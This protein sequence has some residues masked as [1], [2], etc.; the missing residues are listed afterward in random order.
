[1]ARAALRLAAIVGLVAACT[2]SVT[3]VSPTPTVAPTTGAPAA[4][5][6]PTAASLPPAT[7]ENVILG[8]RIIL[9]N[10]YRRSSSRVL[11]GQ[12]EFLG[13]DRYTLQTESAERDAAREACLHDLGDI[14]VPSPERDSD[15]QVSVSRNVSGVSVTDWVSTPRVPGAQPLRTHQTVEA[16]SIGGLEAVRLVTDNATPETTAFVIRAND[17]MYMLGLTQ[18][19]L[20]SRLPKG[21]IDDIARTFTAIA[22]VAFPSPSATTPPREAA[23]RLANALAQAFSARDAEGVARLMKPCWVALTPLIDGQP[24][25]GVLNRSVALFT[26]ALKARYAIG[27]FTVVVDPTV[28]VELQGGNERMFVRSEWRE[29]D[30]TT[31]FDLYLDPI[32]GQWVWTAAQPHFQ[33]TQVV[34]GCI[35]YRSPWVDGNASC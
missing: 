24:P 4:T 15:I 30:R 27:N 21:W 33:R 12:P 34:N 28:Q 22:P 31:Q 29:S 18:S 5:A 23:T 19:S 8:Y 32:D 11:T 6:S 9:P 3:V 20:P 17:R 35:P 26:Q 16:T 13:D 25:G 10:D 14:P 7:F 1:M 2:S